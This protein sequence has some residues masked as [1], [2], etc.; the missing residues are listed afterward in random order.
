MARDISDNQELSPTLRAKTWWM[1]KRV[2]GT[3]ATLTGE[4]FSG[5]PVVAVGDQRYV[6]QEKAGGH[7]FRALITCSRC[8]CD[9][10]DRMHRLT[11]HGEQNDA[12][13]HSQLCWECIQNEAIRDRSPSERATQRAHR[14]ATDR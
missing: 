12:L 4:R 5:M 10:L 3:G 9:M 13:A 14:F 1:G 2:F 6:F 8:R 11:P 7:F